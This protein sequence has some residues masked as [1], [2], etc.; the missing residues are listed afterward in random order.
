MLTVSEVVVSVPDSYTLSPPGVVPMCRP[1][2]LTPLPAV[3]LKVTVD[4]ARVLPGV[5][6]V[7]A[8]GTGIPIVAVPLSAML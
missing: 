5:G 6:D 1:Y 8:A 7:K 4:P 3:Q 2:P